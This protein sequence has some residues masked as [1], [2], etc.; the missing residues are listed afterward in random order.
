M[1]APTSGSVVLAGI[2][3]K[4]GGYGL[5][6]FVMPVFPYATEYYLPLGL[7]IAVVSILYSSLVTLRQVDL[8]KIVAYSSVAHMNVCTLGLFSLTT[9]GI[10]GAILLMIGHGVVS[11][12]LFLLVGVLYDRHHTRLVKYYG[13]LAQVMPVFSAFFL[14]FSLANM[15]LPGT[16][17]F[18]GE[19]LVFVGGWCRTP[20]ATALAAWGTV[21]GAAY[22]LW[23]YNRIA[24]GTLKHKYFDTFCDLT[25]FEVLVLSF[26]CWLSLLL[27]VYPKPVL[28]AVHGPV[29]ILLGV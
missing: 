25:L 2:L 12:T 7:T 3:L 24:F 22:S 5:L 15:G 21:L 20:L 4:L 13:G 27:G 26:M 10:E 14:Y 16:S 9:Q 18:I 17:N 29:S 19:L 6:R 1:E 23:L 8:K 28:D 11:S